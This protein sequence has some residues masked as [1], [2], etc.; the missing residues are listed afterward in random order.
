MFQRVFGESLRSRQPVRPVLER[1]VAHLVD[2]APGPP[3]EVT[4]RSQVAFELAHVGRAAIT[5]L[6]FALLHF[7]PLR[8]AR[9]HQVDRVAGGQEHRHRFID[10]GA[11]GDARSDQLK[12]PVC[13]LLA[14]RHA[15]ARHGLRPDPAFATPRL[16]ELDV[17]AAVLVPPDRPEVAHLQPGH[18][19]R[20]SDLGRELALAPHRTSPRPW[21]EARNTGSGKGFGPELKQRACRTSARCSAA[22]TTAKGSQSRAVGRSAPTPRRARHHLL[23]LPAEPMT[24]ETSGEPASSGERRLQT[25]GSRVGGSGRSRGTVQRMSAAAVIALGLPTSGSSAVYRLAMS[26]TRDRWADSAPA[27]DTRHESCAERGDPV[28][29]GLRQDKSDLAVAQVSGSARVAMKGRRDHALP[30]N[31]P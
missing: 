18:S 5:R 7:Q 15:P 16:G 8:G 27:E 3:G 21:R 25:R 23:V 12:R 30:W 24:T 28:G 10:R 22:P 29:P 20:G 6:R 19:M 31:R 9:Q 2:A 26:R 14:P 13:G 4:T 1:R 11:L 17:D